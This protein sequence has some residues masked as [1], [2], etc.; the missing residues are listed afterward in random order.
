MS[1]TVRRVNKSNKKQ[2][3]DKNKNVIKNILRQ[4]KNK[5]IDEYTDILYT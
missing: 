3:K 1:K 2:V 4:V 5:E